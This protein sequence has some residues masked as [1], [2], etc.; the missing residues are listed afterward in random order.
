MKTNCYTGVTISTFCLPSLYKIPK[1]GH[2]EKSIDGRK[3]KKF[4]ASTI[5]IEHHMSPLSCKQIG[6]LQK[7]CLTPQQENN[8]FLM[9]AFI[10]VGCTSK[11][12]ATLNQ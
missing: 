12:L 4:L 7:V 6:N 8:V 5:K 3:K 2:K 9:E 1:D 10:E 11:A